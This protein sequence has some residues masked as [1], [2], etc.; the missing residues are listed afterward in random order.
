METAPAVIA[1]GS[2]AVAMIAALARA[3]EPGVLK[4]LLS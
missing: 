1:A 2:N 4:V 3:T